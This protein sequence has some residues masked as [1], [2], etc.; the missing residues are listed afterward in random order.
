M[1]PPE[2]VGVVQMHFLIAVAEEKFGDGESGERFDLVA[3]IKVD[4]V[5][6]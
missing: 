5:R 1:I 2:F 3:A 6:R 4:F